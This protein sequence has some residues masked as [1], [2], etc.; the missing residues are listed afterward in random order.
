MVVG[1][2]ERFVVGVV[3]LLGSGDGAVVGRLLVGF[4]VGKLFLG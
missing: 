3:D 4:T 2:L 1:A